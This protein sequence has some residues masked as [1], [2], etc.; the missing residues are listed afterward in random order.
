MPVNRASPRLVSSATSTEDVSASVGDA[1]R[2][3]DAV[4]RTTPINTAYSSSSKDTRKRGLKPCLLRGICHSHS[5][6][7]R[8]SSAHTAATGTTMSA[9]DSCSQYC[10]AASFGTMHRNGVQVVN[11]KPPPNPAAPMLST[12]VTNH[13]SSRDRSSTCRLATCSKSN[14]MRSRA[15]ISSRLM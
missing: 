8:D 14:R 1:P 10:D 4:A 11:A 2:S 13:S 15:I 3:P 5:D 9:T 12:P 6:A 7:N